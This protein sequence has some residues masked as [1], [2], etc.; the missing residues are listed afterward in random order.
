MDATPSIG[1]H[2]NGR[3]RSR[4][5]RSAYVR[6]LSLA[7]VGCWRHEVVHPPSSFCCPF[8]AFTKAGLPL[9]ECLLIGEEA[10]REFLYQS[11]L[12]GA[13][14][15]T[16][17]AEEGEDADSR[18]MSLRLSHRQS[19][20]EGELNQQIC[21]ALIVL[22]APSVVMV[23]EDLTKRHLRSIPKVKDAIREAWL[24]PEGLRRQVEAASSGQEIPTWLVFILVNGGAR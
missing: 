24:S 6:R 14:R 2:S 15:T 22:G 23:S 20:I 4:R 13:L 5:L 1:D 18:S 8:E 9:A 19:P 21:E 16:A 11:G 12:L 7:E 17:H 3:S 10:H